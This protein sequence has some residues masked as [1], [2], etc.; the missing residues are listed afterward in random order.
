[1]WN[2]H[3][4]LLENNLLATVHRTRCR[5]DIKGSGIPW[6]RGFRARETS[7]DL[8]HAGPSPPP[9]DFGHVAR[10][11]GRRRHPR[12]CFWRWRL[13]PGDEC[14]SDG[15]WRLV[16]YFA[17]D[18]FG[19]GFQKHTLTWTNSNN[20]FWG[21]F[22]SSRTP[23]SSNKHP[24]IISRWKT[25]HPKIIPGQS[26]AERKHIRPLTTDNK[27]GLDVD[28]NKHISE[29]PKLENTSRDETNTSSDMAWHETQKQTSQS[30]LEMNSEMKQK[31]LQ[32]QIGWNNTSFDMTTNTFSKNISRW[33]RRRKQSIS[34]IWL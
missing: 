24:K 31:H 30:H 1:M 9:L 13:F 33:I 19:Y 12:R 32:N 22:F 23:T 34:W 18:V 3:F 25:P 11:L 6:G 20:Y 29:P 15:R 16:F 2:T 7:S 5:E 28:E 10:L 4:F 26:R 14:S 21:V 17:W 27:Y 8:G